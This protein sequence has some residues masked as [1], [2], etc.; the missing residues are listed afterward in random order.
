M[1]KALHVRI[2]ATERLVR[3]EIRAAVEAALLGEER[4]LAEIDEAH[5]LTLPA[6]QLEPATTKAA[7]VDAGAFVLLTGTPASGKSTLA[8]RIRARLR[9]IQRADTP[10]LTRVSV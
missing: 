1:T 6:G 9:S 5:R 4:E 10:V 8:S 3:Q 2:V 7:L